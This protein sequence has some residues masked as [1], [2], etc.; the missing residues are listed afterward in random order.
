MD[1][2]RQLRRRL[3][4]E[5]CYWI[6]ERLDEKN[7]RPTTITKL[8]VGDAAA[9]LE[10]VNIERALKE[11]ELPEPLAGVMGMLSP[12]DWEEVAVMADFARMILERKLKQPEWSHLRFKPGHS[13]DPTEAD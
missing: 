10:M 3:I 8:T 4:G 2:L 11:P 5:V 1:R 13:G 9:V 6:C 12:A 7:P